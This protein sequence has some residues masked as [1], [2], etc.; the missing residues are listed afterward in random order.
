MPRASVASVQWCVRL[1]SPFAVGFGPF[2]GG[3]FAGGPI[4]RADH[5]LG[6]VRLGT[7]GSVTGGQVA[8]ST[9]HGP[10]GSREGAVASRVLGVIGPPLGLLVARLSVSVTCLCGAVSAVRLMDEL[11]QHFGLLGDPMIARIGLALPRVRDL[12]ALV[13]DPLALVGDPITLVGD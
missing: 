2:A 7:D 12:L 4:P 8:I 9:A 1:S 13:G 11:P 5:H 10:V 6:P 3:L